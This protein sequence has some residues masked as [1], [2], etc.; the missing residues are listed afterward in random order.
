MYSSSALAFKYLRYLITAASGKGHG[1]HSP[2]IFRFIK[3]VLN[4]ELHYGSYDKVEPLRTKML[5]DKS[6]IE[7]EDFGAGG[8]NNQRTISS[9]ARNVVKSR[10]YSQLLYRMVNY[11]K[12]QHILELGTSLGITTSYL[13]MASPGGKVITME[14]SGE[15]AKVARKNFDAVALNNIELVE[16]NFDRQLASVINRLVA[17]DFAFIDGNHRQEATISYFEQLLP[18][19]QKKSILVFDD[20]HWSAG[21]ENAWDHIQNHPEVSCSVDLF[22]MGIIFFREEF[23]E[24][25]HFTIRF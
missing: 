24:K 3:D 25:Q 9:I 17:V 13:A 7:I 21:M 12:P 4:D 20:I 19:L 18:K 1:I 10:K 11:Y 14:G 8:K 2:F 5:R 15:V 16:G 6:V 22:F 23:R